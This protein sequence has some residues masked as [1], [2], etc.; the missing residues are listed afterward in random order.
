ME[1]NAAIEIL[2]F[3]EKYSEHFNELRAF[4]GEKQ[5]KVA[6]DDIVWLLDS[7]NKEQTFVMRGN[8]LEAKRKL[9]FEEHGI[10][11]F[12]TKRLIE[13]CPEEVKGRMKIAAD[14][15]S[16]AVNY[17]KETN[18]EVLELARRKLE[19]QADILKDSLIA[20]S[21]TYTNTG[22]KIKKMSSDDGNIIGSV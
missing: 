15:I 7:L 16:E 11:G 1:Y 8:S 4:I 2:E 14:S 21:D 10:D 18:Q 9:I 19:A 5:E 6:G 13:E 12:N 3:L 22:S 20:G 17:I